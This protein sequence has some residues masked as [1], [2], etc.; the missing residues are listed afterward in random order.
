MKKIIAFTGSNHSHSINKQLLNFAIE[1]ITTC[2]VTLLDL[3]DYPLP[4]YRLDIEA[5]GIPKEA[6]QIQKVLFAHDAI[7]L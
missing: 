2:E 6:Y 7:M 1:K 4:I 3:S 5:K